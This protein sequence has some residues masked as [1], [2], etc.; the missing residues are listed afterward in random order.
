MTVNNVSSL[1]TRG[2]PVSNGRTPLVRLER[3]VVTREEFDHIAC[4]RCGACCEVVWQPSPLAMAVLI[5]RNAVPGDVLSWWSDLEP[6][7]AV[8]PGSR[9]K[10]ASLQ[11]FRCLRFV[12]DEDGLGVCTQYESRPVACATFPNGMPVH[13]EGFEACSW[14]VSV[15]D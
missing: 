7:E 11:R 10:T 13:A 14:N 2:E 5:G 4:N 12:R 15:L 6:S 3:R 8:S 9:G 1:G